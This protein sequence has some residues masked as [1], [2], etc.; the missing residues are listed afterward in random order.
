MAIAPRGARIVLVEGN[1]LL[2]HAPPW[3]DLRYR[4]D[5]AALAQCPMAGIEP[6]LRGCWRGYNPPEDEIARRVEQ[7]DLPNA[8]RGMAESARPDLYVDT[9]P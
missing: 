3:S 4:F 7:N 9:G 2:L 6:R 1:Y 8:R 5:L